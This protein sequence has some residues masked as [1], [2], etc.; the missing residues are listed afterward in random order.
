MYNIRK[1]NLQMN[2]TNLGT[3]NPIFIAVQEM[4]AR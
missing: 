1:D 2:D 3:H 4:N